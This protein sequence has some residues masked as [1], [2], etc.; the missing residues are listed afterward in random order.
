MG[1]FFC[2]NINHAQKSP[3]LFAAAIP[4]AGA[5]DYD[6]SAVANFASTALWIFHGDAYASVPIKS[7]GNMV[8]ALEAIGHTMCFIQNLRGQGTL[9][10]HDS[11]YGRIT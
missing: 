7:S 9:Y 3:K 2:R 6:E 1:S 4:V 5:A 8:A 11:G 10:G